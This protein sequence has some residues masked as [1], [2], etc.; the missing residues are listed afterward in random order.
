MPEF[1]QSLQSVSPDR[2]AGTAVYLTSEASTIPRPLALQL[3]FQRTLYERTL[4]LTFAR[5]EVP[6]L[7]PEERISVET[8]APGIYRVVARYGFMEQPNTTAALRLA[9]ET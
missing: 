7:T 2:I 8:L 4:I 6:R 9:E 1:L 5:T 3:Q